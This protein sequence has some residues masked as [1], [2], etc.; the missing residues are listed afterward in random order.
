MML[1]LK[2]EDVERQRKQM[3]L[4]NPERLLP[5]KLLALK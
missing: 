1:N 4:P 2:E 3:A 5:P